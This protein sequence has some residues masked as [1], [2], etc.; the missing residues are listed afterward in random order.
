MAPVKLVRAP[1]F[2]LVD[3][4]AEDPDP[5][6][7]LDPD[8]LELEAVPVA[9]APILAVDELIIE[10]V[11]DIDVE[12]IALVMLAADPAVPAARAPI[13]DQRSPGSE[14][15]TLSDCGVGDAIGGRRDGV[16]S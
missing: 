1:A 7:E 12:F 3:A 14:M 11:I 13:R 5:E 8:A 15:L 16:R 4:E 2:E 10:E 6:G 9:A